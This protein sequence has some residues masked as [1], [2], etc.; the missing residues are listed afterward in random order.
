MNSREWPK[1]MDRKDS[2]INNGVPKNLK[3]VPCKGKKVENS[4]Q[5]RNMVAQVSP[6]KN[7]EVVLIRDGGE[8]RIN[9]RLGERPNGSES[10]SPAQGQP[11]EQMSKKLGMSIQTL[12]PDLADQLGYKNANGVLI[13]DVVAGSPAD[14]A[15][16][17]R[18]DLILEVNR[19]GIQTAKDFEDQVKDLKSG[20]VAALL[21][22]RGANTFFVAVKLQ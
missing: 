1:N 7:V 4:I 8:M 11:R 22:R 12:T 18:G 6:G 3:C 5:L 2:K 16:L 13:T 15:S 9:V 19:K 10:E 14:E 21:V 20:D 17:Q